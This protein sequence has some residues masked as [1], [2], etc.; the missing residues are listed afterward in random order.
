MPTL[1]RQV[2][3]L[4]PAVNIDTITDILIEDGIVQGIDPNLSSF[5]LETTIIEGEGLIL[6]P[7]LV[8]LYSYSGE[9]GY[10][11]RETLASLSQSAIAGGFTHVAIIPQT[12]PPVDNQA[13]L[14]L[15]QQRS[16][17]LQPSTHL[18]FW[19]HLTVGGEGQKMTEL[20][21]LAASGVIGFMDGKAIENL[22]LLRRLLEY[23]KPLG[24]PVALVPE[25]LSLKGNG[26]MREGNASISY[27]LPGNP[28]MSEATA[29]AAILEMVAV[30][31]TP[32]HLMRISTRRGVEL[33]AGG[34]SQGIPVTASTTWMHLLLDTEDVANYDPNLRLDPPLGNR[35][36]RQALREGVR[37]GIIDAIAVDHHAYTYEEKT[38]PFA[39]APPGAIGLE[40]A[41]PLLWQE[42]IVSHQW[43]AL[44]L[45]KA[46]S[47]NPRKFLGQ[48]VTPIKVGESPELILFD[49]RKLWKVDFSTLKSLGRN[50]P[51]LGQEI[52]G[53]V[54]NNEV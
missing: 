30:T 26:V 33:M 32:V 28:G 18:H 4:D 38:V 37:D 35:E 8:D 48:P 23:L 27:G 53:R 5:P 44:Q 11:D 47:L 7:G 1:L 45:W 15:L 14:S 34:K 2:R 17:T 36:D 13:T 52:K 9:P 21:E 20:A 43:S 12:V 42:F 41:L 46:L 3:V 54:I 40:L 49:P 24:K 31:Q 6:A 22:G 19:G 10:E 51:W 16:I 39:E 50:T 29:I 25:Y